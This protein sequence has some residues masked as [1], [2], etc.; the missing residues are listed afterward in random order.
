MTVFKTIFR[1][2]LRL[3]FNQIGE[4]IL[5][6]FLKK[7]LDFINKNIL[8]INQDLSSIAPV[9]NNINNQGKTTN[10]KCCLSSF[11][12][13]S[14]KKQLENT[15]DFSEH[16][17]LLVEQIKGINSEKDKT[18]KNNAKEN[19]LVILNDSLEIK[20]NEI[21]CNVDIISKLKDEVDRHADNF[22]ILKIV[23]YQRKKIESLKIKLNICEDSKNLKDCIICMDQ[24]R[25]ILFYP[26]LHLIVCQDC[27]ETN[28][29]DECPECH[30]AIESKKPLSL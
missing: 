14:K 7:E 28:V 8:S 30:K 5:A 29:R 20:L 26:C 17:R 3:K 6:I 27:A 25:S 1:N 11:F 18:I 16:F 24:D 4:S 12:S 10:G 15:F 21:L 9:L 13:N 2:F 23:E 19:F 22:N